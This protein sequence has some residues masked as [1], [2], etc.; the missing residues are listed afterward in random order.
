MASLFFGCV[1][2]LCAVRR[3]TVEQIR[4]NVRSLSWQLAVEMSYRAISEQQRLNTR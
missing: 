2:R 4:I 1:D 3:C